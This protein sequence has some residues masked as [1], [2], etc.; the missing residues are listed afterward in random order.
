MGGDEGVPEVG[1]GAVNA[2]EE[3][4]GVW[5]RCGRE[6]GEERDEASDKEVVLLRAAANDVAMGLFEAAK[7]GAS[8]KEK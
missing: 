6:I 5:Q 4:R 8:G 1:V 3:G 2:A 7:G